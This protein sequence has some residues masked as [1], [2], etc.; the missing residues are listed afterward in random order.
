MKNITITLDEKTAEW[1]RAEATARGQSLSRYVSDVLHKQ[2]P[3]AQAYERA[4]SSFLS[5]A[6][7]AVT[8]AW[9]E[10]ADQG[11]NL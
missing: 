7:V 2:L 8:R 5:R 6:P 11:G 10:I 9:G 1:A 3:K 4:M